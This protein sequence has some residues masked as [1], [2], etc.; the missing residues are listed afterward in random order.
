MVVA[1]HLVVVHDQDA[2]RGRVNIE[3]DGV[4]AE[5]TRCAEGGE[6]VLDRAGRRPPMGD[7]ERP[8]HALSSVSCFFGVIQSL[9]FIVARSAK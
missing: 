4:G 1:D 5:L 6:A 3:F 7:D 8:V 9:S 2:V